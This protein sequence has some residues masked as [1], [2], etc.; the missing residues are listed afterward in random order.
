MKKQTEN[1]LGP[2]LA[3]QRKDGAWQRP[4]PKLEQTMRAGD[5][6]KRLILD[7]AIA[8]FTQKGQA[9]FSLR[10]V[11]MAL[12]ISLGNLTYHYKTKADLLRDMVE[13]RIADYLEWLERL[14]DAQEGSPSEVLS[15]VLRFFVRDLRSPE[16]AFFPQ[17][18]ALA[19]L[20]ETAAEQMDRIY[21]TERRIIQNLIADVK[22]EWSAEACLALALNIQATVEGLTLF[23]GGD[24]R[25]D[26]PFAEPEHTLD[27]LVTLALKD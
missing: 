10:G 25:K 20:D 7:T 18:W 21:E 2:K 15:N 1:I 6:K 13:D 8:E 9:A 16:I 22:P 14:L 11:A 4:V 27:R 19:M 3:A 17:L 26:G 24:R 12:D 23:I 5:R